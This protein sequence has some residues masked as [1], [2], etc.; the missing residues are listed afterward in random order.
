[1]QCP[2]RP[3]KIFNE[4]IDDIENRNERQRSFKTIKNIVQCRLKFSYIFLS[5]L[6]NFLFF[7]CVSCSSLSSSSLSCSSFLLMPNMQSCQVLQP[8]MIC[9]LLHLL[10]KIFCQK[11]EE[12]KK[13]RRKRRRKKKKRSCQLEKNKNKIGASRSS[14]LFF[15]SCSLLLFFDED[16]HACLPPP[17]TCQ[18]I[19][20]LA[21]FSCVSLL[22]LQRRNIFFFELLLQSTSTTS[23]AP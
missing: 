23:D 19:W 18:M 16:V 15:L 9:P 11:K 8:L 7:S 12:R 4:K 6:L 10:D 1:M 13:K 14:S 5:V 3:K 2:R 22:Y 21:F 20:S 17:S